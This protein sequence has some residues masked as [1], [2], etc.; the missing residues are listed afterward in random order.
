MVHVHWKHKRIFL[1]Q[2]QKSI[3]RLITTRLDWRNNEVYWRGRTAFSW[4]Q[5]SGWIKGHWQ[6]KDNCPHSVAL[7]NW[8]LNYNRLP[9]PTS[10]F[11]GKISLKNRFRQTLFL[12]QKSYICQNYNWHH[13]LIKCFAGHLVFSASYNIIWN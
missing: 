9:F 7:V 8:S 1:Y 10:L 13:K 2:K 6:D 3:D 12:I 11:C 4:E 5:R